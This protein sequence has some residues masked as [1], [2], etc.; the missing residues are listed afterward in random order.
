MHY[1]EFGEGRHLFVLPGWPDPWQVPADYL[2]PLFVG[3]PGWHRVY[4][5]LPGRGATR[6][7]PWIQSND[8]VLATILEVV[9]RIARDDRI[10]VAGHSAGG[11][12]A[13][14]VLS[15]RFDRVDGLLQ[16]VPVG[17]V[18]E[19]PGALPAHVTLMR[20]DRVVSLLQAEFGPDVAE[21][22]A[23][24]LVIR[25]MATYERL[26][27]LVPHMQDHD[28]AFLDRLAT[29]EELSFDVDALPT[30]FPHPALFVLGRQDAIVGFQ[31]VLELTE[32]YPRA[33][34][35]VVDGAGHALPWE[36][37]NIFTAL[38]QNW[39]DHIERASE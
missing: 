25:S 11:Y 15:R 21:A 7:E 20:D 8:D 9:D 35:A 37:P 33:T 31:S 22:F 12:L 5:D 13:R 36:Q 4:L 17:R 24:R 19:A 27:V 10:V 39:L 38:T 28:T 14:A 2:E 6:G 34:F 18:N 1:E 23:S 30:P 32:T 29:R 3:R 16:V 26:R